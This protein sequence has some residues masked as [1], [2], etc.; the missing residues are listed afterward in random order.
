MRSA[1][2]FKTF[3]RLMDKIGVI[4]ATA[5]VFLAASGATAQQSGED[6]LLSVIA[7]IA[8]KIKQE[9]M[10]PPG[11]IVPPGGTPLPIEVDPTAGQALT[12]NSAFPTYSIV[13]SP[14][15][16]GQTPTNAPIL[17]W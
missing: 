7:I 1:S 10:L 12:P 11:G 15:P 2:D 13:G 8:V 9:Q 16:I 4:A 6:Y 14:I 3:G 17:G 5:L